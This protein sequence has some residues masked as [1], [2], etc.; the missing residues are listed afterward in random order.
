[1]T[2]KGKFSSWHNLFN[3]EIIKQNK[4]FVMNAQWKTIS[5]GQGLIKHELNQ[6]RVEKS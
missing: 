5:S 1:M 4:L 2:D 6:I 3:S